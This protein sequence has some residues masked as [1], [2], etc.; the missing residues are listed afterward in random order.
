MTSSKWLSISFCEH[1]VCHETGAGRTY[2]MHTCLLSSFW[3]MAFRLADTLLISDSFTFVARHLCRQINWLQ[4]RVTATKSGV[5]H[6]FSAFIDLWLWRMSSLSFRLWL[7]SLCTSTRKSLSLISDVY[8]NHSE[9]D[10]W[11]SFE[12]IFSSPNA[13]KSASMLLSET[14]DRDQSAGALKSGGTD[15]EYF[16]VQFRRWKCA[17]SSFE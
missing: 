9:L 12:S 10:W 17:F 4:P 14:K 7:W 13:L 15:N 2:A 1:K 11:A 8:W 16:S 3:I 6:S 5:T